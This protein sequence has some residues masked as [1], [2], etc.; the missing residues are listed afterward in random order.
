LE[1]AVS[2]A[3]DDSEAW[4]MLVEVLL[5][6]GATADADRTLRAALTACP[7]SGALHFASGRR[8]AATGRYDQAIVEFQLAKK[9]RPSESNP[10]IEL[11][12]LYFRQQR[13]E[14][15]VE[16]M[17]GALKVQPGHPLALQV[18]TRD[19]IVRGDEPAARQWFQELRRQ[20]R[21]AAADL[22]VIA[23]EYAQRFGH[24]PQGGA[25]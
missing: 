10:Y 4:R 3:A 19:A 13:I 17:R 18:L 23:G 7:Q 6:S 8:L 14:E 2:L 12:Q 5:E 25:R 21:V 20:P 15:G 9:L 11:A 24:A 1:K 22:S 16:E